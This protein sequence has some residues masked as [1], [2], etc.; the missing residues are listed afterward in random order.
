[1]RNLAESIYGT[2][3]LA[4]DCDFR[5]FAGA[6]AELLTGI[7]RDFDKDWLLVST[8]LDY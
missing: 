4:V 5:L 3:G 6:D 1:M 8:N 2:F 7:Y